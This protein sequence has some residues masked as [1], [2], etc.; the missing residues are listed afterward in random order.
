[1]KMLSTFIYLLLQTVN[2]LLMFNMIIKRSGEWV[3]LLLAARAVKVWL[4]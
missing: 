3:H 2:N 1:M 4:L